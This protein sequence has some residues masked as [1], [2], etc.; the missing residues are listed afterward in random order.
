MIFAQTR[1]IGGAA[2]I[3]LISALSL[4]RPAA[5][6]FVVA[7]PTGATCDVAR[8]RCSALSANGICLGELSIQFGLAQQYRL[9]PEALH[10]AR[11]IS[12]DMTHRRRSRHNDFTCMGRARPIIVENE[13]YSRSTVEHRGPIY[14]NDKVV[15]GAHARGLSRHVV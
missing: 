5:S 10:R 9:W 7:D 13:R 3:G 4:S 8:R 11:R 12:I 14:V 15:A 2:A 1:P 6:E